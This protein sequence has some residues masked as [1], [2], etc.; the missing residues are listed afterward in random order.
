MDVLG[1]VLFPYIQG[2]YPAETGGLLYAY[3]NVP[4]TTTGHHSMAKLAATPVEG[5]ELDAKEDINVYLKRIDARMKELEDA[6]AQQPE[7][8]LN[9][10]IISFPYADGRAMYLVQKENPL[11]LQHIPYGDAWQIPAAHIRGL[12]LEDIRKM[13]EGDRKLKAMFSQRQ[14]LQ[15][16]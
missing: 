15:K 11:T 3:G 8:T 13:V 14:P 2:I 12:L 6:F 5:F 10:A 1:I 4:D 9:G 7:G 16:S